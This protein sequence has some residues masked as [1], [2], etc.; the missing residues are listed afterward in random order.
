MPEPGVA[1]SVPAA[2]PGR[3]RGETPPAKEYPVREYVAAMAV[4]LAQMARWDGDDVLAQ[5]LDLAADLAARP[6]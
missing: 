6:R 3:P 4:E 2:E 1:P 5:A